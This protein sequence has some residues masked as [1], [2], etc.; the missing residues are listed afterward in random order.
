MSDA[1]YIFTK[2]DTQAEADRAV[3]CVSDFNLWD[4][5]K[6]RIEKRMV[7]KMFAADEDDKEEQYC[8]VL[9]EGAR[10]YSIT[11]TKMLDS[12]RDFE[13]GY[14]AAH[15][16]FEA[17]MAMD[18]SRIEAEHVGDVFCVAGDIWGNRWWIDKVTKAGKITLSPVKP[19]MKERCGF[20]HEFKCCCND[21][22][23]A[24]AST[25]STEV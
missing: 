18:L 16:A 14:A 4:D 15:A 10:Q 8:L 23:G 12:L 19:V 11:R 22:W 25:A 20:C 6:G 1:D 17:R 3:S 2:C 7:L 9:N 5:F 21:R 24:R 13:R